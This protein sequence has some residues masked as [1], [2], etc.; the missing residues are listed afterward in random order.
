MIDRAL[1]SATRVLAGAFV[2]GAL[3]LGAEIL[4]ARS[5]N[6]LDPAA[7]ILLEPEP[8][9]GAE[10]PGRERDWNGV[11]VWLGDSTAIGYGASS[12][13]NG[14]PWR[15]AVLLGHQVRPAILAR[16]GARIRDLV[17]HQL[18]RLSGS[19][20]ALVFISVGANDVMHLTRRKAFLRDYKT[21]LSQLPLDAP[22]ILLG[23]PD[24]GA[25]PRLRQ[26]LRA[27]AG[28]RSRSLDAVVR[29]LARAR[30]GCRHVDMGALAGPVVRKDPRRYLAAD[31]YHPNDDGYA[32]CAGIVAAALSATG[33]RAGCAD[34]SSQRH[35]LLRPR[36]RPGCAPRPGQRGA[37]G[38]TTTTVRSA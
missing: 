28:W 16:G 20:P 35:P 2:G 22:V 25:L 33:G 10:S 37:A 7:S 21:L 32:L 27:L 11:I 9:E 17:E 3:L 34:G 14:L 30:P 4:A 8:P 12:T 31:Q 26:P 38:G 5:G 19:A 1:A 36:R 18:P 29:D 23:V 15:L 6:R 13:A 24:M